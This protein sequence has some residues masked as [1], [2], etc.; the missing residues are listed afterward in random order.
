M[1]RFVLSVL[2][3]LTVCLC[4]YAQT[5]TPGTLPSPLCIDTELLIP[6]TLTGTFAPA[7]TFRV[8]LKSLSGSQILSY[9]ATLKA[10]KLSVLLN[11]SGKEA[12]TAVFSNGVREFTRVF[13]DRN[14]VETVRID[15]TTT[16]TPKSRRDG[17]RTDSVDNGE[18]S[19]RVV[20]GVKPII[21]LQTETRACIN[22]PLSLTYLSQGEFGPNN[23]FRIALLTTDGRFIAQLD[24]SRAPSGIVSLTLPV[25]LSA[26]AC[27]IR[28]LATDPALSVSGTVQLSVP[29]RLMLSGNTTINAGQSTLLTLQAQNVNGTGLLFNEDVTFTLGTGQ[30]QTRSWYGDDRVLVSVSPPQT[31]TYTTS[32]V[33]NGCGAGQTIGSA[34]VT[35]NPASANSLAVTQVGPFS[36]TTRVCS[37][38]TLQLAY[39]LTGSLPTGATLTAQ[40]SD[41][42]GLN[43]RDLTTVSQ[44]AAV[45]RAL[46]PTDLPRAS[47][48][49]VRIRASDLTVAAGAYAYPLTTRYRATARFSTPTLYYQAGVPVRA[50][51]QLGGDG[52]WQYSIATD[53]ATI[54]RFATSSPDTVALPVIS[55]VV[56]FRLSRV[57]T[58]WCGVGRIEDP[59]LIRVELVTAIE[60]GGVAV[61]VFPNPTAGLLQV[62]WPGPVTESYDLRLSS[63]TG[64]TLLTRRS[65]QIEE[66][67]TLAGLPAGV[68]LLRV[69]QGNRVQV[70]R[71]IKQ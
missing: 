37:G 12:Y 5:I 46:L 61:G 2:M 27:Q 60:P 40:L 57:F 15:K 54:D 49:R 14:Y 11:N 6:A 23:V 22:Q 13:N 3:T 55:P 63:L 35:V 7:N 71:V 70:F 53:L 29:V 68:Y 42:T 50:V 45:V 17:C 67:L 47:G 34:V 9:P 25:S 41:S 4:T 43:F 10:G 8:Q 1:T 52:P 69:E 33:S 26:N 38:D 36:G 59:G 56:V 51:V 39:S 44:S 48:Y 18:I 28:L 58:N 30:P 66:Q 65:R 16:Y 24:S 20:V 21:S 62:R 64:E 32:A 31:T 19:G